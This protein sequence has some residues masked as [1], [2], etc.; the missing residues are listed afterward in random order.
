MEGTD[1][2]IWGLSKRLGHCP[3]C[4]KKEFKFY[5][6]SARE[7]HPDTT[8]GRCNREAK[9][10]YADYLRGAELFDADGRTGTEA[11]GT[12]QGLHSLP[13][14]RKAVKKVYLPAFVLKQAEG[15]DMGANGL[16]KYAT[17]CTGGHG[18]VLDALRAYRIGT[19]K[20]AGYWAG[21]TV[22]PYIDLAGRLHGCEVANLD[23]ETGSTQRWT[24]D[25]GNTVRKTS[26][27]HSIIKKNLT[28]E[29]RQV[30]EWLEEYDRQDG[31][32]YACLF[33]EHLFR[34]Y[35]KAKVVVVES[36]K[37]AVL[38][39]VY[40]GLAGASGVVFAATGGAGKTALDTCISLSGREAYL[41]P[42][43]GK[44]DDWAKAADRLSA[45]LGQDVR[46]VEPDGEEG[47]DAA[48]LLDWATW[49][50]LNQPTTQPKPEP[51][52]KTKAKTPKG[53]PGASQP[54]TTGRTEAKRGTDLSEAQSFLE[55]KYSAFKELA[56]ALGLVVMKD[57]D[58]EPLK[59]TYTAER[60]GPETDE[61]HVRRLAAIAPTLDA[62]EP[63]QVEGM[64]PVKGQLIRDWERFYPVHKTLAV[65][66]YGRAYLERLEVVAQLAE[67]MGQG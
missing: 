46:V 5:V 50:T 29:G 57:E 20:A 67:A 18:R 3:G 13:P 1:N 61:A 37:T 24:D 4:G 42:D 21:A 33:G 34:R 11:K 7:P 8:K 40:N 43:V 35:P 9:C 27:L 22:Y 30:P 32:K 52:P 63:W 45:R 58:V 19:T 2:K 39:A 6:N 36:P 14:R 59:Y 23:P 25:K 16:F 47:D 55:A 44:Y 53:T 51:K 60:E 48:D 62:L 12:R 38:L 54:P 31:K 64:E 49:R 65:R 26:H 28:K 41:L 66:T 15:A 56:D 10:G 17:A